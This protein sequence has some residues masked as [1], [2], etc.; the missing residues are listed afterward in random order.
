MKQNQEALATKSDAEQALIDALPAETS[1]DVK[2]ALVD[3]QKLLIGL[4]IEM[5]E[6]LIGSLVGE[7][8]TEAEEESEAEEAAPEAE[9]P[10]EM[11][12]KR[13]DE[14]EVLSKSLVDLRGQIAKRDEEIEVLKKN[15]EDHLNEK[16]KSELRAK[17]EREL[18]HVP[19]ALD[20]LV[21]KIMQDES[22]FEVFRA[23]S[24]VVEKSE[25]LKEIG[26]SEVES[27][28][29]D[30]LEN[31]IAEF[32]KLNPSFSYAQAFTKILDQ[33]PELKKAIRAEE[34]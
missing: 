34:A 15:L 5:L 30:Q 24:G 1:D 33:N 9:E 8:L 20:V 14:I 22:L 6:A 28:P 11:A 29:R 23:I 21:E 7:D 13:D 25:L 16:K 31:R 17:C 27:T 3:A 19:L 26:K 18:S 4:P 10:L 32:R 2:A 12:A